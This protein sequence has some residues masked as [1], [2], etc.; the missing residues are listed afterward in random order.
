MKKQSGSSSGSSSQLQLAIEHHKA[1]RLQQAEAIYKKM[2]G[3]PDALHLLG[4]IAY[5]NGK[6]EAAIGSI[7]SAIRMHPA[8]AIYHY[9]LGL[10]YRAQG[11]NTEAAASY[12][13]AIGLQHDYVDAL[14]NLGVVLDDQAKFDEAEA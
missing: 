6:F 13:K 2:S 10:C 3:S 9:N 5:Q 11:Q 14:N 7:K 8:N 12:R 4:V 1:G